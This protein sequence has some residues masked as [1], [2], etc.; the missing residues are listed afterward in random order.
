[1][2]GPVLSFGTTCTAENCSYLH[3]RKPGGSAL[4]TTVSVAPLGGIS[5]SQRRSFQFA[6]RG[7]SAGVWGDAHTH[8]L[9]LRY[10]STAAKMCRMFLADPHIRAGTVF[11]RNCFTKSPTSA[12]SEYWGT[13]SS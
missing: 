4:V 12:Y 5:P 3:I 1:M 8:F 7:N 2:H 13:R 11:C 10:R 6:R 9:R